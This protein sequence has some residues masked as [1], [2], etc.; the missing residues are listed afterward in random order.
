[1]LGDL[2]QYNHVANLKVIDV[3]TS[4]GKSIPEVERLFSHILNAQSIW[5]KRIRQESVQIDTFQIQPVENFAFLQNESTA[6][7]LSI[8]EE[9]TL[10]SVVD[11]TNSKGDS[12]SNT[13]NDI[14]YHIIN[15]STYHRGQIAMLFRQHE[16]QPPLTEY[17]F[18]KR[19]GKL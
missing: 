7:L 17:I 8:L 10:E 11:Y 6:T 3:F 1:M 9:D 14:L 19:E 16:V 12:F 13:V 18:Y 15:H 5:I 2:I 4:C